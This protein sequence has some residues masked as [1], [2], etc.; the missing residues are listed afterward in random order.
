[1]WIMFSMLIIL[2]MFSYL[3]QVLFYKKGKA[4]PGRAEQGQKKHASGESCIES[5]GLDKHS[6]I[7][8]C[9]TRNKKTDIT[10]YEDEELDAFRQRKADSYN[11]DEIESFRYVLTTMQ[12]SDIAGWMCSLQQRGI[13]LPVCLKE[14]V[15]ILLSED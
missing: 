9:L 3:I 2:G 4:E 11:E 1:M 10:Y 5:C 15:R 12:R 6:C 13:E 14:E 8:K 7:K